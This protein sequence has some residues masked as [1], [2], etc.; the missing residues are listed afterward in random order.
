LVSV[1]VDGKG[2]KDF[3]FRA[4]EMDHGHEQDGVHEKL[5]LVGKTRKFNL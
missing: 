2:L 5:M 3:W 1:E 4:A